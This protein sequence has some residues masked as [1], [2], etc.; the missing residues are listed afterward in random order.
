MKK[1]EILQEATQLQITC[2]EGLG[3]WLVPYS[4]QERTGSKTWLSSGPLA[5]CR[6]SLSMRER[7]VA[8]GKLLENRKQKSH[9][10]ALHYTQ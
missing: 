7:V 5:L 1:P 10:Q 9:C 8:D 4:G 2:S 6:S 3:N